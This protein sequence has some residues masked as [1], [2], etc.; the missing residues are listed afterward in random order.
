MKVARLSALRTGCLYSW[1]DTHVRG[2]ADPRAAG[3]SKLITLSGIEPITS[4][5]VVPYLDQLCHHKPHNH[6]VRMNNP[7]N[8][9][10][11]TIQQWPNVRQKTNHH[12][13]FTEYGTIRQHHIKTS[14]CAGSPKHSALLIDTEDYGI[15]F[16]HTY[17]KQVF[18]Y[19]IWRWQY[20]KI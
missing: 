1:G 9:E 2:L 16:Y 7:R 3:R 10:Q 20:C 13:N 12:L 5:F 18:W 8:V 15:L 4:W 19:M 6:L 17:V 11:H 14:Y